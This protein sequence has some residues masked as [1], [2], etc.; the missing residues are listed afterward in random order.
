MTNSQAILIGASIIAASIFVTHGIAP[1]AAQKYGGPFELMH[2]SNTL[3][4]A[5]V[6]RLDTGSGEVSYCYIGGDQ[7]LTCSRAVK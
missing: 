4:N 2:H 1:A 6:F 5:G 3:A 7:N